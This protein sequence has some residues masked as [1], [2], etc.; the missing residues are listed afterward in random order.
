MTKATT[1][2]GVHAAGYGHGPHGHHDGA[3][4][5]RLVD[6]HVGEVLD[7]L[8]A[9]PDQR[10]RVNRIKDRILAEGKALHS[11]SQGLH[12]ELMGLLQ[13]DQPD[14]ARLH[15]LVDSRAAAFRAFGHKLADGVLE[16]HGVLTPEQRQQLSAH[17]KGRAGGH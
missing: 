2:V 9:T 12:Q 14:A 6:A 10:E 16:L 3:L 8:N 11:G 4:M 5:A 7:E 13:Q 1:V 15:E 17:A